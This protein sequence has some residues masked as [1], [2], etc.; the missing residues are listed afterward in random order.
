MSGARRILIPSTQDNG[1]REGDELRPL[2]RAL[3]ELAIQ[4]FEDEKEKTHEM[5]SEEAA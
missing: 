3:I 2:A 1:E 4:L 5:K